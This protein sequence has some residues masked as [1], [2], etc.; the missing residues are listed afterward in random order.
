M[1]EL[2][3]KLEDLACEIQE[4]IISYLPHSDILVRKI[5]IKR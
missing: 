1:A 2:N 4:F 5:K 3:K